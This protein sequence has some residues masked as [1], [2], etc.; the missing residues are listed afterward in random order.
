MLGAVE[1]E[2]PPAV[3]HYSGDG[4]V[5]IEVADCVIAGVDGDKACPEVSLFRFHIFLVHTRIARL[6]LGIGVGKCGSLFPHLDVPD[7]RQVAVLLGV[8]DG[9]ADI[10]GLGVPLGEPCMVLWV[11]SAKSSQITPSRDVSILYW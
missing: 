8:G 2:S 5:G 10:A 6:A 7:G 11:R 4:V 3:F 9:E 1:G